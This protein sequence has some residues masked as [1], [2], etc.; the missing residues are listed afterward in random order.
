V[1]AD[2]E[3]TAATKLFVVVPCHNEAAPCGDLGFVAARLAELQQFGFALT[4]SIL[5]D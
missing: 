3:T 5:L 4:V 2:G 1:S